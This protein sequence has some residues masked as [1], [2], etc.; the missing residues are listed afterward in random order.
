MRE[1]GTH[2]TFCHS[3]AARETQATKAANSWAIKGTC[4]QNLRLSQL[5]IIGCFALPV[6]HSFLSGA[7]LHILKMRANE[8]MTR[9]KARVIVTNVTHILSVWDRSAMK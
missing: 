4:F 5:H 2:C 7:I 6:R 3:V 8:Q 9:V 1:H